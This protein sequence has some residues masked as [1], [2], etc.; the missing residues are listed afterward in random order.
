MC[1]STFS[2]RVFQPVMKLINEWMTKHQKSTNLTSATSI[3]DTPEKCREIFVKA[4]FENVEITEETCVTRFPDKEECWRQIS[5]S[6]IVRPRLSG[7]ASDDYK[8]LKK[9]IL[10][11]LEKLDTSQG[12]SVDVP[13]IFC[14]VKKF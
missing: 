12:I 11:E 8:I 10:S 2:E 14:T 1:C 4:G 7:L 9:E 6:L 5:G 3:T 13:V